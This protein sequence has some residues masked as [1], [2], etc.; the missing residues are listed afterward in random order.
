M[1]VITSPKSILRKNSAGNDFVRR[2]INLIEGSGVTLTF[3]DD[4]TN[5][6]VDITIAAS[7]GGGAGSMPVYIVAANGTDSKWTDVADYTCDGTA[8]DV[9]IQ[10][11]IDAVKTA[12]GT[13]LLSPG[14]FV[15]AAAIV[16]DGAGGADTVT[17]SLI[18][19]GN[20]TTILDM[21]NNID[22]IQLTDDPKVNIYD[23][24]IQVLGTGDGIQ[25]TADATVYR[26]FW[27][28]HFKNI[29][30]RGDFS[31]HSGW[32][33]NFENPFRSLFENIEANGVGNGIRL[34][35]TNSAFNPG[36]CLFMRCFM[37][38][39]QANGIGYLLYTPDGGGQFNICTFIQCEAIDSE[40]TSTTSKGWHFRGSS[41]TYHSTKNIYVL[42]SNVEQFNKAMVFEHAIQ[43][44][45]QLNY[46][47]VKTG[48]T[49]VEFSSDSNGN[50]V[51]ILS[52]YVAP[53]TTQILVNDANTDATKPNTIRRFECFVDTG[54]TLNATV[55]S[56]TQFDR[57]SPTTSAGTIDITDI[58]VGKT[59]FSEDVIV[60]DDAYAAG[61]NGNNEVP[62]KNAV[63][64]KVQTLQPL[65]ATLTALAA[66]NTS[67]ILTQTAA[68]TFT[69]RTI[70]G[71]AAEITVTNGDGVSGNPTLSLPAVIDLG[72]KTSFEI[73]NG[74]S[75]TVD[76]A[77]EIAIDTNTDNSVITQGS[78]IYHD[79]TRQMYV[80]AVDALPTTDDHV[81]A[82]DGTAKKY[83]F[84]AQ[85]GGGTTK[86]NWQ[87]NFYNA[88]NGTLTASGNH[89]TLDIA[90][91]SYFYVET[92]IPTTYAGG[93]LTVDVYFAIGTDTDTGHSATIDVGIMRHVADTDDLDSDSYATSNSSSTFAPLTSTGLI[94]K[95][96]VTF[97]SGAQMDSAAAGESITLRVR[98]N[99]S[100]SGN[101]KFIAIQVRET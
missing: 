15:C 76:A 81:L 51:T 54:G 47:D 11:A 66:Y 71:T 46:V 28:S 35:A 86:P 9:Q 91:A 48:G 3:S 44:N 52:G 61:W 42:S 2:R 12:G 1:P 40:S 25:A 18:G 87:V 79:G 26:G 21:A 37:D 63:Y 62:T 80:I 17:V 34:V 39:S 101:V 50:D 57:V 67:G 72:G 92:V 85:S 96:A 19:Q 84:Q 24:Q 8:D 70:T 56:A 97:T 60:P 27:N 83:V 41:T 77:G 7:G 65:D 82:Y 13:V 88:I 10:A 95:R 4:S 75:P 94:R 36:N 5:N 43:N 90:N 53:S 30:I 100:I 69:G 20:E 38:L 49:L 98:H 55:T 68:D 59:K 32:A 64:D 89:R 99:G 74:T 29:Y 73:P 14:T 31:T 78:V 58:P 23:L 6:E 33:L 16:I 93:G 22:G 45:L